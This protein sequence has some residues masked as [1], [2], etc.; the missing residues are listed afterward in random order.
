M[1][2][3][4]GCVTESGQAGPRAL[5]ATALAVVTVGLALAA[6][7]LGGGPRPGAATLT[8]AVV[9]T[10]VVMAVVMTVRAGHQR[11]TT[12]LVVGLGGAQLLLHQWFALATPGTCAG[13]LATEY[14]P[15][16]HALAS[17][18]PWGLLAETARACATTGD[19]T[20]TML[21]VAVAAHAL[22]ALLTGAL[23]TR[24]EALLACAVALLLP[25][26]PTRSPVRIAA[27]RAAATPGRVL[28]GTLAHRHVDRRGPPALACAA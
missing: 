13:H 3:Y 26:L 16:G 25:A 4:R 7:L 21:T 6:H 18:L 22:A 9:V 1:D 8:H 27:P 20:A 14:L 5:R 11:S 28:A 12:G 24:G 23:A 15:G 2:G 17:V 19:A 10:A